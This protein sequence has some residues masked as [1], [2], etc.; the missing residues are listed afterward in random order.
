ML[1][2]SYIAPP[3]AKALLKSELSA[4]RF[5][6][7]TGKLDNEIYI[8]NIHNAPNVVREVG[9]LREITFASADGGTGKEVDL[10]ELDLNEHCYQ[11]L[12]VW[13]PE[14]EEI[15]RL[16]IHRRCSHCSA[17]RLEAEP[18]HGALL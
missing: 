5:I 3:V 7:K 18:Q 2:L 14:E 15:G 13:N 10:D 17:R 9:R 6:R 4:E 12:I 8:V 1:D 16:Q 11:Q